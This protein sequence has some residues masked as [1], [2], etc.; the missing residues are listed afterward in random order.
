MSDR[1]SAA[2]ITKPSADPQSAEIE[3]YTPVVLLGIDTVLMLYMKIPYMPYFLYRLKFVGII[4]LHWDYSDVR[5]SALRLRP[6]GHIRHTS[7][8]VL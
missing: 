8:N 1:P 4:L 3:K 7:L 2:Y 6:Y 5:L